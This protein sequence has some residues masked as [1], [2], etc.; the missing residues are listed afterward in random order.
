M[1]LIVGTKSKEIKKG[2]F[3]G[4]ICPKCKEVSTF[5]YFVY[6]NYTFITLIPLFPVGKEAIVTCEKCNETIE[7]N[8]LDDTLVEKLATENSNLKNPIWTYF[9]SFA[10]V[11]AIIYG[12]YSYFQ[13]NN[14]TEKYVQNPTVNDVYAIKDDKGFYYTFRIDSISN[15][16]IYAT[17]SDYQAELPY[18]VDEINIP[19][20]YTNKK[21]SYSKKELENLYKEDCI[22][23]IIRN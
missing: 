2:N 5:N 23:S 18:E 3:S 21:I 1:L 8:D 11:L 15:D 22:S 14:E 17:E 9:G 16:S 4:T 7:I 12:L 10:L 20:N 6:T 13:S 19:E